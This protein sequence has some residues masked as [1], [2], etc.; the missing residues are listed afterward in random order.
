MPKLT[1]ILAV[2]NQGQSDA[3]IEAS[4][5]KK[6]CEAMSLEG[7]ADESTLTLEAVSRDA[8]LNFGTDENPVDIDMKAHGMIAVRWTA[9]AVPHLTENEAE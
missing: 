4:T 7:V 3:D 1:V 9:E 8:V 6:A 5:L 2:S